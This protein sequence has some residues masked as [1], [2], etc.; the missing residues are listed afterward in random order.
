MFLSELELL[1]AQKATQDNKSN[2][3]GTSD[4]G[5][6][7]ELDAGQRASPS[8]FTRK[9]QTNRAARLLSMILPKAFNAQSA[10][11]KTRKRARLVARDCSLGRRP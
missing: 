5:N 8:Q 3:N 2:C 7:G 10:L 6:F 4:E 11:V 9:P 1:C